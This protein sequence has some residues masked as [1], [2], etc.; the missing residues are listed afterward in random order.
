MSLDQQGWSLNLKLP[1]V[2]LDLPHTLHHLE[3]NKIDFNEMLKAYCD[4]FSTNPGKGKGI[5][6]MDDNHIQV[7]VAF[8]IANEDKLSSIFF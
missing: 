4:T 6:R 5:I 7:T 3:K 2:F 1:I 8:I